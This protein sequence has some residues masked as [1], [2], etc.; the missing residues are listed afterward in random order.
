M[1]GTGRNVKGRGECKEVRLCLGSIEIMENFFPLELGNSDVILG[2][3]W[4]EKLGTV[5][6]NWMSQVMQFQWNG[7]KVILKGD[8]GLGRSKVSL[9]SMMKIIRKEQGGILVESNHVTETDTDSEGVVPIEGIPAELTA[10]LSQ[11]SGVF[12]MP[13]GLPPNRG[14]EHHIITK[15]GS[16]PVSV[17]SYRYPQIQKAEIEKMVGDMLSAGIIKP[18]HSPYSSLVLLVKKKDGSW[19]FCVD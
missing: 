18:S 13:P 9:K 12:T 7:A 5:S 4:L 1:L 17:R 15:E 2:I 8:P 19:R 14:Q 6:T 16:D 10:V 3:Q 11:Y